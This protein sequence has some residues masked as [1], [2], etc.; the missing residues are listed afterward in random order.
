MQMYLVHI[1]VGN[2][3]EEGCVER[4]ANQRELDH[5]IGLLR[6]Q[7]AKHL[8]LTVGRNMGSHSRVLL[9]FVKNLKE[10]GGLDLVIVSTT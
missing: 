4:A 10:K 5:S 7:A 8:H 6:Y 2:D 9:L 1:P 3:G